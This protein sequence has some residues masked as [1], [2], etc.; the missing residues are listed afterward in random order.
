MTENTAPHDQDPSAN[1]TDNDKMMGLLAY[2]LPFFVPIV[3]LLSESGKS[4]PF[5]RYH[6]IN[7]LV[8]N[9]IL[10]SANLICS[11]VVSLI[12]VGI[13]TLCLIPF[14]ILVYAISL[15]YGIQ[16]YQGEYSSIP[17]VTDFSKGQR[18]T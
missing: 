11:C 8:L 10:F 13:G 4:R 9:I 5:Q 7:S 16:A 18:W 1:V 3:I 17:F 6:A 15:Y 2:A 14:W 12:T